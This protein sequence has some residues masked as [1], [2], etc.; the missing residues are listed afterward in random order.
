VGVG[1][2]TVVDMVFTDEGCVGG[3]DERDTNSSTV[4]DFEGGS[5]NGV[6]DKAQ[7]IPDT[8]DI[9]EE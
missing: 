2:F 9:V 8:E 4:V 6:H 3:V 5:A 1:T 7:F